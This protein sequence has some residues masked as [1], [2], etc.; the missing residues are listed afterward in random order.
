MSLGDAPQDEELP[1]TGGRIAVNKKR[2]PP[3]AFKEEFAKGCTDFSG[4]NL[5]G[6]DLD[7]YDLSAFTFFGTDFTDTDFTGAKCAGARF[8]RAI[9]VRAKFFRVDCSSARLL[10]ANLTDAQFSGAKCAGASFWGSDCSGAVFTDADCTGASFEEAKCGR[11]HFAQAK[12]DHASFAKA[13]CGGAVFVESTCLM[14]KFDNA[15]CTGAQFARVTGDGATFRS[16]QCKDA[17]FEEASL[18]SSDFSGGERR[19]ANADFS[20]DELSP[21]RDASESERRGALLDSTSFFSARLQGA[22]LSGASMRGA[23]LRQASL[24]GAIVRGADLF[25][26]QLGLASL[27]DID[28]RGVHGYV[29]DSNNVRGVR[30]GNSLA[31]GQD[32]WSRLRQQYTGVMTSI[33]LLLLTLFFVPYGFEALSLRMLSTAEET[34]RGAAQCAV[35]GCVER[36]VAS[37]L[38]GEDEGWA[39]VLLRLLLILYNV[40]RGVFAWRI[41]TMAGEEDRSDISPSRDE[42]WPYVVVHRWAMWWLGLV[43]IGY[44]L[45][46]TYHVLTER[47]LVLRTALQ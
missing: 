47:V 12:C 15:N 18:K 35:G 39:T 9:C 45:Y 5:S 19:S 6:V 26:A 34:L 8:E 11:A 14:A 27:E 2:E 1:N 17:S 36:S 46:N 21:I 29:L 13:F 7:G 4:W 25:G 30:F 28:L 38:L 20:L 31:T 32:P 3:L 16:S 23:D 43:A 40:G 44:F 41:G 22:N 24:A 33:H 37:V 42:Y 10:G